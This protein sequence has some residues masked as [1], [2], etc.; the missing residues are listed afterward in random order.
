M[1]YF[2]AHFVLK[3]TVQFTD[4]EKFWADMKY[5]NYLMLKTENL[6]VTSL[7]LK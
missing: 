3:R 1:D 4:N 6:F 7:I 5:F 2:G